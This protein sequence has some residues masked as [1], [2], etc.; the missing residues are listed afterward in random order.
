M[1]KNLATF[2]FLAL[3]TIATGQDY[4]YKITPDGQGLFTLDVITQINATRQAIQRT[5]KLD[6]AAV[7]S[8]LYSEAQQAYQAEAEAYAE[9]IR[10]KRTAINFLQVL[11][12]IGQNNYIEDTRAKLDSFFVFGTFKYVNQN[13]RNVTLYPV[14]REGNTTLL[15]DQKNDA[16][17]AAI[18]PRSSRNIRLVGIQPGYVDGATA[19]N[20]YSSD[21]RMYEGE[22]NTGI[23]HRL[24]WIRNQ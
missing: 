19:F 2:L 5:V 8:R 13:G 18:S 3:A 17:F 1:R 21:Q 22:D 4:E 9:S 11:D 14:Y 7:V 23:R 10:Q 16:L 6:T 12:A 24:I 15:R 20:L